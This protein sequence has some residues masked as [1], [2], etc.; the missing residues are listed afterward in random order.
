VRELENLLER[1]FILED[2]NRILVRHLPDRILREIRAGGPTSQVDLDTGPATTGGLSYHDATVA[3]QRRLIESALAA[4]EGNLTNA[5]R[6]LGLSR[7]ALRH[8]M[9]KVGP[10]AADAPLETRMREK[11]AGKRAPSAP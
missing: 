10:I 2:D 11:R 9:Q 5:A 6:T 4:S 7:H 8:Q 1:I 3:Y